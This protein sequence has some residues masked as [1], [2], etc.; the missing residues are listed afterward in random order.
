[1]RPGRPTDLLVVGGGPVGLG[2][3]I[4]AARAGLGTVVL[5]S[6]DGPVDKACGEGLMPPARVALEDLGVSLSGRP[7][8]GIRYLDG[9]GTADATF[10][11]GPGLGVRRTVLSAALGDRADQL[12]VT[13]LRRRVDDISQDASG[14]EAGGVR[15]RWL[16]VA[17]GLHSPLRRRLGLAAPTSGAPRYGLRRHYRIAPWDDRVEVHWGPRTEAYVTPVAGDLV[18]VAVLGGPGTSYDAHLAAFPALAERLA[19]A[20]PATPVRGAGPLRQ[21]ATGRIAGRAF[22]VGDAAGYVDAL[23]GEG[24][25]TGLASA[26]ALVNCLVTGRP[27]EYERA[28]RRSSRR[29]RLV[30]EALLWAAGRPPVRKRIVPAARRLPAAFAVVVDLLAGDG[31]SRAD[32]RGLLL[33]G[34]GLGALGD[35]LPEG[36]QRG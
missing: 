22:L 21:R 26:G 10:R 25:A 35:G 17:D 28:W 12:G 20:R 7:F 19:G 3:A 14:V 15:A 23:T 13:R 1:M 36:D 27:G 11:G 34:L 33:G 4:L 5:E 6:R 29:Y 2:T 9:H 18:G 8:R 30:T 32:G 24:V 16:A 31:A